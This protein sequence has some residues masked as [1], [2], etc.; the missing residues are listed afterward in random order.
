MSLPR[1][2]R[3]IGVSPGVAVA[4]AL[5]TVHPPATYLGQLLR[6]VVL[7]ADIQGFVPNPLYLDSYNVYDMSRA[8]S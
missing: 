1:V 4:P 6:Y 7:G 8:S 3:G 5:I 2:I